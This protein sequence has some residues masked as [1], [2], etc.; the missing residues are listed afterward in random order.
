MDTS[1]AEKKKILVVEDDF[2]MRDLY[3]TQVKYEGYLAE[4]AADGAEALVKVKSELP[5]MVLLDLMLPKVDGLT[6]LKTIKSDPATSNIPVV[7]M[8]N[9]ESS[10]IEQQ[11][12]A[13]G[14]TDYFLKIKV[15]PSEFIDKIKG[16]L[17]KS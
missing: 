13:A 16:Y 17:E 11:A 12:K 15:T 3:I 2:Y 4:G 7:I 14:A 8:T 6:V 5:D 9:M 10:E 1:S